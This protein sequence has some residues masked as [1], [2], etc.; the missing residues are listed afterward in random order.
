MIHRNSYLDACA[1]CLERAKDEHDVAYKLPGLVEIGKPI[2][3]GH[4][5]STI[6]I[7]FQCPDCGTLWCELEDNDPGN[8]ARFLF[9][10]RGIK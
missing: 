7:Y 5:A 4:R 1:K 8:R 3:I 6:E 9:P 10:L 2:S